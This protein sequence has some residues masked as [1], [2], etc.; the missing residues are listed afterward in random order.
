MLL[1]RIFLSAI[2]WT[3]ANLTYYGFN[4]NIDSI[5]PGSFY[6]NYVFA[7]LFELIGSI[8]VPIVLFKYFN[9]TQ[10]Q[11]MILI[12]MLV[13]VFVPI[14]EFKFRKELLEL[15]LLEFSQF[16]VTC[17]KW[18]GKIGS[19]A[20][21][22]AAYIIT[23]ELFPT[24][25]R[26]VCLSLPDGFSRSAAAITPYFGILYKSN[27]SLFWWMH[28]AMISAAILATLYMPDTKEIYP[29]TKDQCRKQKLMID[30]CYK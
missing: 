13:S 30:S 25:M 22:A 18:S 2:I 7:G 1:T 29:D 6:I 5:V 24:S 20:L 27:K 4:M 21:F 14:L 11:M 17:A 10:A 16:L 12:L 3:V 26:G 9:R 8:F 23:P 28:V 15:G 19:T